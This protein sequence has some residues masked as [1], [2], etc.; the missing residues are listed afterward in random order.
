MPQFYAEEYMVKLM[1][2]SPEELNAEQD[3]LHALKQREAI[4]PGTGKTSLK[5]VK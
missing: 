1:K 4:R 3:T 2:M 5:N